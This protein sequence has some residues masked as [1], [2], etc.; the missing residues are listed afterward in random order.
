MVVSKYAVF[1]SPIATKQPC[2]TRDYVSPSLLRRVMFFVYEYLLLKLEILSKAYSKARYLSEVHYG[3]W[4]I[5]GE[6]PS[7]GWSGSLIKFTRKS[8]RSG[9]PPHFLT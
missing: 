4:N 2:C 9:Y 3:F 6:T 1:L 8:E 5:K 7:L